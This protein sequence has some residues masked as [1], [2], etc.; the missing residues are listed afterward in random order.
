MFDVGNGAGPDAYKTLLVEVH[1]N[2]V[3]QKEDE[4]DA[5]SFEVHYTTQ[6]RPVSCAPPCPRPVAGVT[7]SQ[8]VPC[9]SVWLTAVRGAAGAASS[10]LARW[11]LEARSRP[12]APGAAPPRLLS[13][14]QPSPLLT[15]ARALATCTRREC[16]LHVDGFAYILHRHSCGL[17]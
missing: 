16:E 13:A 8:G 4:Y 2:N 9:T 5:T 17:L 3:G 1:Y 14:A 7:A 11:R 12:K 6:P 15:P 10:G